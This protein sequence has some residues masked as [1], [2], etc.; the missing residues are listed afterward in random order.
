MS[1]TFYDIWILE[2]GL[3]DYS[4]LQPHDTKIIVSR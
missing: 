2:F 4:I 1:T 3:F